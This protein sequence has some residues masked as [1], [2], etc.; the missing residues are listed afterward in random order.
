MKSHIKDIVD[1]VY[2]LLR[3]GRLQVTAGRLQGFEERDGEVEVT[4]RPRLGREPLRLRVQRV[5]NCT[6][7]E[8]NYR[9]LN[10]PL[11][12]S[13][14]ERGLIQPDALGLGLQTDA[15]GALLD[16]EGRAS[17]RLHTLGPSRKGQLWETTA[18]PEIRIQAQALAVRLLRL[19]GA[20]RHNDRRAT[21]DGPQP[22]V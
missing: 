18:V 19:T 1:S 17:E 3:N 5:V 4:L 13:L 8:S 16:A 14:R 20:D 22:S 12:V 21:A 10:H 2:E 9:R 15:H 7:P 6:G 11:V